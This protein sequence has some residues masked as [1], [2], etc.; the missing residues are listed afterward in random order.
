MEPLTPQHVQAALDTFGFGTSIRFFENSTAT[1]QLAADQIG[2]ELGQIAKSICFTIEDKPIVVIASGDQRVDDRKVA[3]LQGVSRKQIKFATPEQCIDL[4][5]Y[6]PGG[7]PPL[8]HRTPPRA[9][10]LDDSLKRY[11]QIYPAGGASNA[12]FGVTLD[13]LAII[14]GGIFADIRREV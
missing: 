2:V 6:A 13:Q 5:G 8:A 9:V 3:A 4:I 1:S 10:Y 14:T 12:I 7:V 11:Q